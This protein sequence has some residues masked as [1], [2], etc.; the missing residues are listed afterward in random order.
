[1]VGDHLF[2][3]KL[4]VTKYIVYKFSAFFLV[5]WKNVGE[6]GDFLVVDAVFAEASN[7]FVHCNVRW[8]VV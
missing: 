7:N 6:M 3:G 5:V 8:D 2:R 4:G 1:M